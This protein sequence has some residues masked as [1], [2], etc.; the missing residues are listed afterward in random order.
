MND[1]KAK[2]SIVDFVAKVTK[3]GGP[4][5][6]P[7]A[8]RTATFDNDG[9]NTSAAAPSPRSATPMATCKCSNGRPL[10]AARA[11]AP[12]STTPTQTATGP[13]TA[14]P[15]LVASTKRLDEAAAKG[16]TVVSMKDDWKRI[17]AF[18]R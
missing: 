6:V 16:W 12:T 4:D 13:T 15:Q 11:F 14:N 7:P 10:A 17:F 9:R 3:Q 2:Q 18:E 5:F 1:G 8:E